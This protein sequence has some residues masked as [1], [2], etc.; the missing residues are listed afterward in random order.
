VT[1]IDDSDHIDVDDSLVP[2][3]RWTT[4]VLM[5]CIEVDLLCNSSVSEDEIE[6]FVGSEDL[7]EC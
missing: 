5:T 7:M 6:K 3:R 2:L 1:G 4:D